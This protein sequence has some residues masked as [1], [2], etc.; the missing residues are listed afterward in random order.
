MAF[1]S[2]FFPTSTSREDGKKESLNLTQIL[3]FNRNHPFPACLKNFIVFQ[4]K[5]GKEALSC[6][7][8]RD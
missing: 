6:Q 7:G 5:G 8:I 2:A 3:L 1:L 4:A